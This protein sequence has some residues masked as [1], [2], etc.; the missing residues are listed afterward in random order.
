M[1]KVSGMSTGFQLIQD[2]FKLRWVP[3][4]L[5][6]I[7]AGKTGYNEILSS[8]EGLS[9]TELNRKLAIL[10]ARHAVVKRKEE[11]RSAYGLSP[12]GDDLEHVFRHFEEMSLKYLAG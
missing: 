6:A 8:I 5:V 11:G 9:N 3:E 4:I 2:I 7:K 1:G 12:F 10:V